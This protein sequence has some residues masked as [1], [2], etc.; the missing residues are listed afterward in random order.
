VITDFLHDDMQTLVFWQRLPLSFRQDLLPQMYAL[1]IQV[2]V[3]G[4]TAVHRQPANTN[5]VNSAAKL[6]HL[7]TDYVTNYV[8]SASAAKRLTKKYTNSSWHMLKN[9]VQEPYTRRVA[10]V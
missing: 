1:F 8:C 10:C 4:S 7:L 5:G 9:L 3:L 2:Y 6:P